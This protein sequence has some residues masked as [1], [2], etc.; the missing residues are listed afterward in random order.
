MMILILLKML[1][2]MVKKIKTNKL[3]S[4]TL[5]DEKIT[6]YISNDK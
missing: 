5:F 6:F 4:S 3:L 2:L 1:L